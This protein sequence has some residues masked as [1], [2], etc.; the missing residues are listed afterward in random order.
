MDQQLLYVRGCKRDSLHPVCK[1]E[2][3]KILYIPDVNIIFYNPSHP[4]LEGPQ[5]QIKIYKITL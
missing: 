5:R 1:E 2:G 4:P 3:G